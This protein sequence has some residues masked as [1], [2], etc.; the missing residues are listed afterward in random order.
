VVAHTRLR[1]ILS[2]DEIEALWRAFERMGFDV[3]TADNTGFIVACG[4]E[5]LRDMIHV[6]EF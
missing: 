4:E 1:T 3:L 2:P 6:E 5:R